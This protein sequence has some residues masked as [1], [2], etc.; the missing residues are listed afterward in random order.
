MPAPR[1]DRY[2]VWPRSKEMI[3]MQETKDESGKKKVVRTN[4][5]TRTSLSRIK[6][7]EQRKTIQF[8]ALARAGV[9]IDPVDFAAGQSLEFSFE[10]KVSRLQPVGTL[11]VSVAVGGQPPKTFPNPIVNPPPRFYL[12]DGFEVDY[13]YSLSGS[14]FLADLRSLRSRV[15]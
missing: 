15:L 5:N 14:E 10:T 4:P 6:A 13:I 3:K 2:Y 1:A 11:R 7:V 8:S 9:H 12:G